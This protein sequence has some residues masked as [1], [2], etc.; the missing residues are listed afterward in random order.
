MFAVSVATSALAAV[1]STD[2]ARRWVRDRSRRNLAWWGAG[3]V[4]YGVG[5]LAAAVIERAGWSPGWFRTW[6]IAGAVLGGVLLAQGTAYLVHR[7]DT[8]DRLAASVAVL[9]LGTSAALML[10]PVAP[11][12]GGELAGGSIDW[13]WVRAFTPILNLYAAGY[14]VGG[15]FWSARRLHRDFGITGRRI[16]GNV[17]IALGGLTPALGGLASRLGGEKALPP[18]LLVG[19]VSI[20]IG[21]VLAS[22]GKRVNG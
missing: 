22:G 3:V 4:A 15:A 5:T 2:L 13:A 6:Y 8:A 11:L 7:R 9:A 10:S 1:F 17:L 12:P 18:T 21:A 16:A 14:L 20:W 19:L